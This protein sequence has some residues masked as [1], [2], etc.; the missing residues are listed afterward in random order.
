LDVVINRNK[1]NGVVIVAT[2]NYAFKDITL[3][4]ILSLK[5]NNYTGFV[6]LSFDERLAVFL[7]ERG[8]ENHV[9]IVPSGWS[10]IYSVNFLGEIADWRRNANF[11]MN[12]VKARATI[13]RKLADNN[14]SFLFC[15]LDLVFLSP[16]LLNY[17]QFTF[18]NT[19]SEILFSQ[20]QFNY[21]ARIFYNTGFFFAVPTPFVKNLFVELNNYIVKHNL[22]DQPSLQRLVEASYRNDKRIG[23]LDHLLFPTG[24]VYYMIKLNEK[25][26]ITPLM[27]HANYFMTVKEKLNSFRSEGFW[28]IDDAGDPIC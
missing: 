6:V 26:K 15:D 5:R 12:M 20:D 11:L 10:G 24:Y 17:V 9:A 25:W 19:I 18:Q 22:N 14:I 7:A 28:Y 4:W 21:R 13:W 23:V 1:I 16:H 8:L 27:Y 3:N 2:S